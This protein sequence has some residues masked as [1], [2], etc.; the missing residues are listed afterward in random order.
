MTIPKCSPIKTKTRKIDGLSVRYAESEHR[1]VSAILLSPWP[2]SLFTFE[3]MWLRLAERAHLVA[4]DLPGF[5]YSERRNE[6][7]TPSAMGE[8]NGILYGF[9]RN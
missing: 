9:G 3:Q 7:L 5:G 6:L 4:I 1:D 2:E 8:F